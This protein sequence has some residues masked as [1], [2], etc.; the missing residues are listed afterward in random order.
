MVFAHELGHNL[1][2]KHAGLFGDWERTLEYGDCSDVMGTAGCSDV[3]TVEMGYYVRLM[4]VNGP[5]KVQMGWIPESR[6][7]E[8]TS[9]GE[10]QLSLL[11]APVP[12]AQILKIAKPGTD[13][14]EAYYLSFRT[15]YGFDTDNLPHRFKGVTSIT[16]WSGGLDYTYLV[17]VI[18]D[19]ETFVD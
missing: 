11:E 5:H 18:G 17:T 6:V 13:S 9:P 16:R 15:N 4:H 7:V 1:G 10:Y 19:G 3:D 2:M 14:G 12:T 8:V